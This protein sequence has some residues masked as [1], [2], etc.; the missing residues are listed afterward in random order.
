MMR[1][2]W[3]WDVV[4]DIAR[5]DRGKLVGITDQD[6]FHPGRYCLEQVVHEDDVDHRT[7]IEYQGISFERMFR[8]ALIPL[9]RFEL[10]Q[11]VDGLGFHA[12]C[13]A[14]PLGSPSRG[15]GTQHLVAGCPQCL[16]DAERG[17]CLAGSW[18]AGEYH[19]RAFPRCPDGLELDFIIGDAAGLRF[20]HASDHIT[21]VAVLLSFCF[22]QGADFLGYGDLRDMEGRK[23]DGF[24]FDDHIPGTCH[25]IQYRLE[26]FSRGLEHLGGCMEQLL[27]DSI[28]MTILREFV[29]SVQQA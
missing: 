13:L 26:F 1:L 9:W 11:P 22:D 19:E 10:E 17:R 6:D 18:A 28:A 5:T 29:E 7:L 2:S 25:L 12:G 21:A 8:I 14:H 15:S 24:I 4:Q 16:D 3:A 23:I 27:F 20:G